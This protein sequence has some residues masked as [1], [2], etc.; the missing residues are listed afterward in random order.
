MSKFDLNIEQASID[1]VEQNLRS[2]IDDA[3][4]KRDL[5]RAG[6]QIQSII[7]LRTRRGEYLTE[8]RGGSAERRQYRSESWKKKR[9]SQGL[10][11]DRVTLFFGDGGL[12]EALKV[13]ASI[14]RGEVRI[15]VGYIPGLSEARASEIARYMNEQG[16]GVNRVLYRYVGLTMQEEKT[17]ID[18]LRKTVIAN[19][20]KQAKS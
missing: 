10:P 8:A 16:V 17:V 2:A 11:T 20:Q 19:I 7:L 9:A 3:M 18:G 13:Q 14:R 1:R 6:A 15:D 5:D 12:L 4:K